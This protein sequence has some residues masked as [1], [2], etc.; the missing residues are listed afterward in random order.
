[1]T[2]IK[3]KIV[4][5]LDNVPDNAL[6]QIS[7]F[8]EFLTWRKASKDETSNRDEMLDNGWLETDLSNLGEHDAYEWQKGE[9]EQGS[10]VKIDSEQGIVIVER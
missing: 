5:Q 7:D 6:Q 2:N 3:D 1:M 9:L 10:A 8:I 4:K